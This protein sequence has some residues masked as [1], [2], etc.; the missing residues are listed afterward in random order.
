MLQLLNAKQ[1]PKKKSIRSNS[2]KVAS[3]YLN[4]IYVGGG[5]GGGEVTK[6]L[7]WQTSQFMA[8]CGELVDLGFPID[9]GRGELRA[10]QSIQNK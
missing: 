9:L 3:F 1:I 8:G 5:E 2:S 4:R 6:S 7:R 10:L